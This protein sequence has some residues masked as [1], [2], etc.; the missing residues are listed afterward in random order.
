MKKSNIFSLGILIAIFIII[1]IIIINS[2]KTNIQLNRLSNM[3]KD[4]NILED[5]I[6]IYYLDNGTIPIKS[7]IED[8]TNSVNPNDNNNYYEIDLEKLENINLYYGKKNEGEKDIYIINEMSHTI[9]YY[10]GVKYNN[11]NVFSKKLNYMEVE[12]ENYH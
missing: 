8:F 4:I 9:Y 5:K 1:L 2:I 3:F 6:S 12:I 10:K 7:K 11:Y